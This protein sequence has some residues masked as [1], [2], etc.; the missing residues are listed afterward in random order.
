MRH[1]FRCMPTLTAFALLAVGSTV[2]SAQGLPPQP[3]QSGATVRE[4][5]S[6][7]ESESRRRSIGDILGGI[8]GVSRAEAQAAPPT[9]PGSPVAAS[10]SPS[11]I[12]I[13]Q[14]TSSPP[15]AAPVPTATATGGGATSTVAS[16]GPPSV[17]VSGTGTPADPTMIV[18]VP[19]NAPAQSSNG[20]P[21]AAN[22]PISGATPLAS[23]PTGGPSSVAPAVSTPFEAGRRGPV[24]A[25]AEGPRQA[26]HFSHRT[27]GYVP[28]PDWCPP[29]RW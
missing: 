26:A 3:D 7:A 4:I 28:G 6:R 29:G 21:A 24:V 13:A 27:Y 12:A 20:V 8:A 16:S 23:A 25:I 22:G 9:P 14:T 1:I 17:S 2:V 11:P 5:L 18:R 10:G 19:D 15:V